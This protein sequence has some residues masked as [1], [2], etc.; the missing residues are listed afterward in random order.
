MTQG[1]FRAPSSDDF[2]T[3][4]QEWFVK[5][6]KAEAKVVF[7]IEGL[8]S[9]NP[10]SKMKAVWVVEGDDNLNIYLVRNGGCPGGTMALNGGDKTSLTKEEYEAFIKKI[11]ESEQLARKEKLG[12]WKD[13]NN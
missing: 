6:P 1:G 7:E 13:S 3:L 9:N 12:V 2:E 4:I 5:H 10:N 8:M 11:I